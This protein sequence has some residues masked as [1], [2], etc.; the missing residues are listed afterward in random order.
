VKITYRHGSCLFRRSLVFLALVIVNDNVRIREEKLEY[1][2]E[3]KRSGANVVIVM[4]VYHMS[5][6]IM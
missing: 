3:K 6:V 1:L 2:S 4:S 5:V